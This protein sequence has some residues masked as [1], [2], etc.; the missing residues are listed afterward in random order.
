MTPPHPCED[1]VA[2][3]GVAYLALGANMGDPLASL[4]S[5]KRRLER[6]AEPVGASSLYR[7]E[8]VGGPAGQPRYLNAVLVLR[9]PASLRDPR[10]LLDVC[11]DIEREHGRVRRERWSARTLDVDVLDLDGRIVD[12]SGLQLPHPRMMDRAFVLAPLCE[13]APGW[14]HPR[15]GVAACA[16]LSEL[17]GSGIE[18]TRLRWDPR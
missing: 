14:T 16:R 11:L 6:L 8:P 4:R 12:E 5:A 2:R 1:S 13:V 17:D 9:I 7:T 15:S 10:A 3:K 18:R